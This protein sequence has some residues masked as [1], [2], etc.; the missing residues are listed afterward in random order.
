MRYSQA[1]AYFTVNRIVSFDVLIL[2]LFIAAN[3]H[4][5]I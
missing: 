3:L 2:Y 5:L 4:T 1:C